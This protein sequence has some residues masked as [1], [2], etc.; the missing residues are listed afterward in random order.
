M[1]LN[2]DKSEMC[3]FLYYQLTSLYCLISPFFYYYLLNLKLSYFPS[4]RRLCQLLIEFKIL[5]IGF[6]YNETYQKE[7]VVLHYRFSTVNWRNMLYVKQYKIHKNK[8]HSRYI[9]LFTKYLHA[10]HKEMT[11]TI[12]VIIITKSKSLFFIF[13]SY[14]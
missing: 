11:N 10:S 6:P 3:V 7:K 2:W 14:F 12:F 9:S 8:D 5:T 13:H 1:S 4:T